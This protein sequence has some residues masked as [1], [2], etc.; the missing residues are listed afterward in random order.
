M[1]QMISFNVNNG[2]TLTFTQEEHDEQV[3]A[4]TWDH[5]K[6]GSRSVRFGDVISAGDMVMLLNYYRYQKEHGNPIF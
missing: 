4:I 5:A 2:G 1:Y 3:E 6:D